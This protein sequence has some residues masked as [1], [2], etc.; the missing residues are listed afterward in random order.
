M[1]YPS[2]FSDDKFHAFGLFILVLIYRLRDRIFLYLLYLLRQHRAR[3]SLDLKRPSQSFQK[4]LLLSFQV[5]FRRL[6]LQL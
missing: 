2:S 1:A 5:S 6:E 4:H 3:H